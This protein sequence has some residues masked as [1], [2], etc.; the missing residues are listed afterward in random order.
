MSL[1]QRIYAV[2]FDNFKVSGKEMINRDDWQKHYPADNGNLT[3]WALR[4]VLFE[5][6]GRKILIDTG[7]GELYPAGLLSSFYLNGDFS[8]KKQ[9]SAVG[10]QP[11]DIDDVILTHLHFDHC[12][13][14]LMRE[15][16]FIRP[17]FPNATL[18]ISQQQ[19]DTA[20]NPLEK[21][22]DSFH[23][24]TIV[25]LPNFYKINFIQEEGGYLPGVFFRLVYGHTQGQIIPLIRMDNKTFLFGADLFPSSA[26]L[27][28]KVNMVYD[29]I[30][31]L[32]VC[33]KENYLNQ[34]VENKYYVIFQHGL[35]IECCSL[36]RER[37]NTV[38]DKIYKINDLF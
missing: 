18:W 32:S 27:S 11:L 10:L 16:G 24:E 13:G 14:C 38:I 31:E 19:W 7:F 36:K 35:F 5:K 20:L 1:E 28:P 34:I 21:E 23:T 12:G 29:M 6:G 3:N 22:I 17:Q 37:G 2:R 26:H 9:L 4:S 25:K 15:N 30:P 33:E 8:L